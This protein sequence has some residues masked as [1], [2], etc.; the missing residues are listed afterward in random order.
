MTSKNQDVKAPASVEVPVVETP[1]FMKHYYGSQD[2]TP[3]STSLVD[4]KIVGAISQRSPNLP[5]ENA[6][7]YTVNRKRPDMFLNFITKSPQGKFSLNTLFPMSVVNFPRGNSNTLD[8]VNVYMAIAASSGKHMRNTGTP[9]K[10][11]EVIAYANGNIGNFARMFAS[12]KITGC[13]AIASISQAL[14]PASVDFVT[15]NYFEQ[16]N[17]KD[18]PI[19]TVIN[20]ATLNTWKA[21]R[22]IQENTSGD[23]ESSTDKENALAQQWQA[24]QD[25]RQEWVDRGYLVESNIQYAIENGVKNTNS[26]ELGFSNSS[27]EL[28]A[29]S[30]YG[31]EYGMASYL[32]DINRGYMMAIV[33]DAITD[34]SGKF[35]YGT[36]PASIRTQEDLMTITDE[37]EIKNTPEVTT[38][39][40]S[41]TDGAG[42][43]VL[44]SARMRDTRSGSGSNRTLNKRSR[45]FA[46][47]PVGSQIIILG[48]KVAPKYSKEG[49]QAIRF[50]L[51]DMNYKVIN[52]TAS[53]LVVGDLTSTQDDEF[54]HDGNVQV[55]SMDDSLDDFDISAL[56][57]PIA[58]KAPKSTEKPVVS[59][60]A[61]SDEQM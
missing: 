55:L 40:L 60:T 16:I 9:E 10:P 26:P 18:Y 36:Y 41:I 21:I 59:S 24:Y 61:K 45:A 8:T 1:N 53:N 11:V 4:Q 38:R 5:N 29:S 2:T 30:I 57:T 28:N 47:I 34:S 43:T 44:V 20:R 23:Y 35:Q 31:T 33:T 7:A 15:K 48:C 56:A 32:P 22:N 25:I 19:G 6:L 49:T 51:S 42:N 46:D 50:E 3:I 37:T 13:T 14:I 39:E 54:Q 17:G 27:P 12:Q 58:S 52:S